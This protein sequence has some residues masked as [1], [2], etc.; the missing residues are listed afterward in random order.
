MSKTIITLIRIDTPSVLFLQDKK[1]S[2]TD[3]SYTHLFITTHMGVP[4]FY[5]WMSERYPV[6]SQIVGETR[7]PQ[8]DNLYLDMNGIIHNCSHPNDADPGF[9]LTQD[10]IFLAI[11]NYIEHLFSKIR[12]EKLFF[13]AVD[14]K[15]DACLRLLPLQGL[16]HVQ[17]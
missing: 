15:C 11:F 10:Q 7:I 2:R 14:G 8:F 16:R 5:R 9:R 6:C 13:L 1:P 17:R 3:L 4:K 12:P